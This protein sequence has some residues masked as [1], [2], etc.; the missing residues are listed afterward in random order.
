VTR[1]PAGQ[2]FSTSG[3][4]FSILSIS[5]NSEAAIYIGDPQSNEGCLKDNSGAGIIDPK[6]NSR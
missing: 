3:F 4:E 1:V 5:D 2:T 6:A